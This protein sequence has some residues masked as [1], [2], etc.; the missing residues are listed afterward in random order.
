MTSSLVFRAPVRR[1]GAGWVHFAQAFHPLLHYS[2]PLG[3][4][5]FVGFDSGPAVRS[6]RILTRGL[7]RDSLDTLR[8]RCEQCGPARPARCG[9]VFACTV[10]SRAKQNVNPTGKGFLVGWTK[11]AP[12]W[13]GCSSRAGAKVCKCCTWPGIP[14]GQMCLTCAQRPSAEL[15]AVA[16]SVTVS[17]SAPDARRNRDDEAAA[18]AGVSGKRMRAAMAFR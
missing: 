13:N 15:S 7:H 4:Y 17:A 1:Y 8:G 11:A 2:V 16:R 5:D 9:A 6:F 14:T 10:A 18:H 12:S 3:G